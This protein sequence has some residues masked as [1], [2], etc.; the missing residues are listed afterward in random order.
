VPIELPDK[1]SGI[2]ILDAMKKYNDF[3]DYYSIGGTDA[4]RCRYDT[5]EVVRYE[6]VEA[7]HG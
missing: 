3:F 4:I 1:P 2:D 6:I 5:L 7:I